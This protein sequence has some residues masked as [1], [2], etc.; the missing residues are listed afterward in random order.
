MVYILFCTKIRKPVCIESVIIK[1]DSM[2]FY[3]RSSNETIVRQEH[4]DHDC[5][6]KLCQFVSSHRKFFCSVHRQ[7]TKWHFHLQFCSNLRHIN[8]SW[9]QHRCLDTRVALIS[10]TL[11]SARV[12]ARKVFRCSVVL[13]GNA[14]NSVR[15]EQNTLVHAMTAEFHLNSPNLSTTKYQRTVAKNMLFRGMIQFTID[16][17]G[18]TFDAPR[19]VRTRTFICSFNDFVVAATIRI[20]RKLCLCGILKLIGRCFCVYAAVSI[21][22]RDQRCGDARHSVHSAAAA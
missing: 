21:R 4:D 5:G 17:L 6:L 22:E 15:Y 10:R 7:R 9:Q 11:V 3:I 1:I 20:V 16:M 12:R 13:S 2:N 8:L 19:S 14:R 18:T